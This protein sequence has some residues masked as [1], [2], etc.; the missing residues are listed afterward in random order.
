M[1][2]PVALEAMD[3]A[4]RAVVLGPHHRMHWRIF[5]EAV[6]DEATGCLMWTGKTQKTGHGYFSFEGRKV[7]AHRMAYELAKGR[8][9][10]GFAVHHECLRPGCLRPEHLVALTPGQHLSV[11]RGRGAV[12][13]LLPGATPLAGWVEVR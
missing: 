13:S 3:A 2:A 7:L 8:V 1:S 4:F 10:R 11:H 5:G 6:P 12:V 9:P